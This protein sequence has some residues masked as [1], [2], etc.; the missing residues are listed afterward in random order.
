MLYGVRDNLIDVQ[1]YDCR[2]IAERTSRREEEE[3]CLGRSVD[4]LSRGVGSKAAT[5]VGGRASGPSLAVLYGG[6]EA[7]GYMPPSPHSATDIQ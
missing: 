3:I 5:C 7:A 2:S 6:E 1:Q 4:A